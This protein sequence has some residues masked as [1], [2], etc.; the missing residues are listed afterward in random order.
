MISFPRD[1]KVNTHSWRA[2]FGVSGAEP[3]GYRL[4]TALTST[5]YLNLPCGTDLW[6]KLQV[7]ACCSQL[8]Q[9]QPGAQRRKEALVYSVPAQLAAKDSSFWWAIYPGAT[10][11]YMFQI[12]NHCRIFKKKQ[13]L[14]RPP[15][16]KKKKKNYQ[17]KKPI[18]TQNPLACQAL[19]FVF[20]IARAR[21]LAE[22]VRCLCERSAALLWR[23][24]GLGV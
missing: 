23:F 3:E 12:Q 4:A 20:R 10:S 21:C 18:E 14:K 15:P 7:Q 9:Y 13:T 19:R 2:E 17:N 22:H 1:S 8:L 24:R 11:G 5:L 6:F 16:P